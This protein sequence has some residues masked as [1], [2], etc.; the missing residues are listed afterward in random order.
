MEEP[1]VK[2]EISSPDLV[3]LVPRPLPPTGQHA[4]FTQLDLQASPVGELRIKYE[5]SAVFF[6]LGQLPLPP[7]NQHTSFVQLDPQA[8]SVGNSRIKHETSTALPECP[9]EQ[10]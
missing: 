6:P 2:E 10:I 3:P 1:T 8:S 7:A 9:P 4:S 5:V